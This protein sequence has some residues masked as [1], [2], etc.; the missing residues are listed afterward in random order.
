M[1]RSLLKSCLA[2]LAL[3]ST[4][5]SCGGVATTGTYYYDPYMYSYYYPADLSYS[6]YYYTDAWAYNGLYYSTDIEQ[7][8]TTSPAHWSVGNALRALARGQAICPGQVTVTPKTVMPVCAS[9]QS[10]NVPSGVTVVF[11]GCQLTGGGVVDGTV[12]VTAMQTTSDETCGPSTSITLTH[13]TVIT[14][15]S[16]RGTDGSKLVIPDQTDTGTNNFMLGTTP[17]SV[18]I[19][20]T[21]RFQ[22]YDSGQ[23]LVLDQ[24]FNGTRTF[25]FAGTQQSYTVDGVM[26]SQDN[27]TS[28]QTATFTATG[29]TRTNDC[30]HP[31]AGSLTLSRM[32][33][34]MDQHTFTFGPTCGAATQDGSGLTLPACN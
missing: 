1:N 23:T 11:T 6:T 16:Y 13:K 5:V 34:T 15:L 27:K 10:S 18:N 28:G 3:A 17:T 32:G 7:A 31:T 21:G 8:Q 4:G 20:S 14:N 26:N 33:P 30:C 19:N 25:K 2:G 22:F 9:G 24:N 12:D 29:L